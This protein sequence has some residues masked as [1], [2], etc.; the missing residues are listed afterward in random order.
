MPAHWIACCLLV[1]AAPGIAV[2]AADTVQRRMAVTFDDLPTAA[3]VAKN[4]ATRRR[5]T[6]TL[7]AALR[8]RDI[9]A[10]GFVNERQLY[11]ND[12]L[13]PERVALLER[14]L[15]AGLALGNHSY[16]HPDLHL[17]TLAAF[18]DDVLRGE[19]VLEALLR[20]RGAEPRYFRHPYLHTGTD[21]D[22]KRALEDFLAGNGYLVAPVTIDNSEWIFARAYDLALA[23]GDTTL[24]ERVGR[25]YVD[26]MLDIV[27][28]Y[29]GQ[30][31]ALFDRNIDH[32][33]LL[34]ANE[35][36]ADWFGAL[37][38]RL[39]ARGYEFISLDEALG[40][41]AYA[42]ED[43]YIGPGGITWLHRWALT[44]NVDPELFR[45]EPATPGYI[46]DATRLSEHWYESVTG[47]G[48][49]P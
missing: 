36:N 24:G 21:L 1:L 44:R 38:D 9:P 46:L 20:E 22:T 41:P 11:A 26:Y 35:L 4:D 43:R 40:D 6:E 47:S 5:M 34:H 7:L 27:A 19:T 14:W 10:I 45:G 8:E 15:D 32:V 31:T 3:S 30:S 17:T 13:L 39:A 23:A 25:D 28:F 2:A 33:L 48:G 18:Q 16:S 37:A 29:E 49:S 12:E 42:S